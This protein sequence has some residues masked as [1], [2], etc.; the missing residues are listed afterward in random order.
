[1]QKT[2]IAL[3][4]SAFSLPLMAWA[5]ES[6]NDNAQKSTNEEVA[7]LDE[8]V[9]KSSA[10]SQQIG[11]QKISE[12]DIARRPATNGNITDLLKTNP[13]VRFSSS[14]DNANNGGEI[15]PSE[16]S[17]HGERYYNNNY[18]LDGMSNNDNM[19]PASASRAMAETQPKG[20]MAYDLP[21]G[22]TQSFWVD[23]NML[24]K[25]E[26]L[27]SNIS[28][29][30]GNFTGGVINA[31]MKDPNVE[32]AGGKVG[33]RTTRN[34][35]ANFFVDNDATFESATQLNLQP[36]FTKH[37]YSLELNQ[38]LSENAAI[39]FGYSRKE[40]DIQYYHPSLALYE[41]GVLGETGKFGNIQKRRAET[42][43]L[44]G[45]Y[46]G[47][48][49]SV[50]RA[51]VMYSPN[52]A[53][54]FK[55]NYVNGGFTN[56]GGG[57]QAKLEWEKPF[58][59]LTM[60]TTLGYKNTGNRVVHEGDEVHNY[61][62]ADYVGWQSAS[63]RALTGGYGKNRTQKDIYTLKQKFKTTEFDVGET[64]HTLNFGWQ[65]EIATAKYQREND[66]VSYLYD[67]EYVVPRS[68]PRLSY[69]L[70]DC[71]GATNC[72]SHLQYAR[73]KIVYPQKQTRV[74]DDFYSA[75][76]ED[77]IQWK[78]LNVLVG[79]RADYN[80]FLE[81]L[82]LSPRLSGAYDIWGDSSTRIFAGV[83]RYYGGSM[84]AT[85]L[86]NGISGYETYVRPLNSDGIPQD[87]VF[88]SSS[89][90]NNYY[91]SK[92]KNPYS[93]EIN[94]GISQRFL[95][96][97][98]TVKWVNRHSKKQL[99]R[100]KLNANSYTLS[101]NAWSKNDT[102]TLSIKPVDKQ[103][104]RYL[105]LKYEVG[106]SY[107]KTKTNSDFYEDDDNLESPLAFYNG[108][109]IQ[110]INGII[111]RDFN[112]PWRAFVDVNLY[113]PTFR[114]NWDH[115]LSYIAGR[116]YIYTDGKRFCNIDACDEH[117]G[118]E[119]SNYKDAY[120][121]SHLLLDWRFSYKQPTFKDQFITLDLDINNVLNRK[122]VAKAAGGSTR[123]KMGRNFWLGASYNW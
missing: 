80:R 95:N 47:E 58:D 72:F 69:G 66:A 44:S 96:S 40:S 11:T 117:K 26:V 63:G 77:S 3:L 56:T 15:A 35:W 62:A 12:V 67:N 119:I 46:F 4:L 74:T 110:T 32:K 33:Y 121:A 88:S 114:L 17:F 51:S 14:S 8:V 36:I 2:K 27:D 116:K 84:L 120:Q 83:N 22:S 64:Q 68:T 85:A 102:F 93:D 108:N 41:N 39:L 13:N 71:Q 104:Y 7:E 34:T 100:E 16:V 23:A 29:E 10:F 81:K 60:K 48:D 89:S 78:K 101:N 5:E 53:R 107:N 43:L 50:W 112:N 113:F 105:H 1:M 54:F 99:V 49:N 31:E 30:Y 65:V 91:P 90:N 118:K 111:P 76:I 24:K 52:V 82:N 70:R 97:E 122:A 57:V 42:Y 123:Y 37:E 86:R 103:E 61:V 106:F 25:V 79:V 20:T 109:L 92:L 59:D 94:A 73:S 75:Y 115:R 87:W 45:I 19:D 18:V 21:A 6:K 55:R 98:W 38:P 9:V 28:A